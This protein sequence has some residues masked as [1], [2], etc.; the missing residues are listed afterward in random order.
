MRF[1]ALF[2]FTFLFSCSQQ[3]S[4][5]SQQ[6]MPQV[7]YATPTLP[8]PAE[9]SGLFAAKSES[10]VIR[11]LDRSALMRLPVLERNGANILETLGVRVV[12]EMPE[13]T[14]VTEADIRT[15]ADVSWQRL[16]IA[17]KHLRGWTLFVRP[18]QGMARTG[19]D[20]NNKFIV[21]EIDPTLFPYAAPHEMTHALM[22]QVSMEN[23]LPGIVAEFVATAAEAHRPPNTAVDLFTYERLNRPI[24]ATAQSIS[25]D[26]DR[27]S[28]AGAPL[29]S[30]RYELLRTAGK[31]I[32]DEAYRQLASDI[33]RQAQEKKG[34]VSLDDLRDLFFQAGIGDCVL[35]SHTV[36]PGL[37]LDVTVGTNQAPI[38]LTKYVDGAGREA[39]IQSQFTIVWKKNG[40]PIQSFTG[41]VQPMIT[42]DGA[43]PFA[44]M[45]DEYE[46]TIGNISYTYRIE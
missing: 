38:I 29:D 18:S 10:G 3:E 30:L 46:I 37:Y 20:M 22:G 13:T 16:H 2:F 32:G 36:E 40:Q 17:D 28:D 11:T 21:I 31:K 4:P 23:W 41:A 42:D 19:F 9:V 15:A 33:F 34:P 39:V 1:L 43:I 8:S 6:A 27:I 26:V 5:T 45:M 25:G 12:N 14:G 44:A 35:F 7:I 24:L